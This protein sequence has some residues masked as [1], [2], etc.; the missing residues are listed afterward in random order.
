M[1]KAGRR[2]ARNGGLPARRS[3]GEGGGQPPKSKI[4]DWEAIVP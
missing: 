1:K 2:S 4:D 3:L